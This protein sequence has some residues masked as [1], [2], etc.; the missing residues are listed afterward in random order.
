[1][2][3]FISSRCFL[4]NPWYSRRVNSDTNSM[5]AGCCALSVAEARLRVQEEQSPAIAA[6]TPWPAPS[7]SASAHVTTQTSVVGDLCTDGGGLR[8][9][10]TPE[11]LRTFVQRASRIDPLELAMQLSQQLVS[12]SWQT[13]VRALAGIQ[14]A[15]E[16][17]SSSGG[18]HAL[19]MAVA[20][21]ASMPET[22]DSVLTHPNPAVRQAALSCA[23]ALGFLTPGAGGEETGSLV[24]MPPRKDA[25]ADLLGG[26]SDE[27][28][29]GR[30]VWASGGT[31]A[32]APADDQL[33][34]LLGGEV[35]VVPP[36]LAPA[37]QPGAEIDLLG[38]L[39]TVCGPSPA[40]AVQPA[41]VE[42]VL[43]GLAL[44]THSIAPAGTNGAAYAVASKSDPLAGLAMDMVVP[45][46]QRPS[47]TPPSQPT[48]PAQGSAAG[49]AGMVTGMPQPGGVAGGWAGAARDYGE[50]SS[51][52]HA[53]WSGARP[54]AHDPLLNM[55]WVGGPGSAYAPSS[56]QPP[57]GHCPPAMLA[58]QPF[59]KEAH[60]V[61][62]PTNVGTLGAADSGEGVQGTGSAA[63]PG[64]CPTGT[65]SLG[66][67]PSKPKDAFDFVNAAMPPKQ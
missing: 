27:P 23:G 55:G 26:M 45:T 15:A 38:E 10:P 8:P 17:V 42:D 63:V 18:D 24:G 22:F 5:L 52:A 29:T 14:A 25:V 33:T 66:M 40:Q 36:A 32:T 58:G 46:P 2:A 6:A 61:G 37:A 53:G 64:T 3:R 44:A 20:S 9:Q 47:V 13:R 31:E 57:V 11:Q 49:I 48:R 39:D 51:A 7:S 4:I 16:A 34:D 30:T 19:A 65:R 43:A 62:L 67:V 41:P 59:G 35:L 54:Q 56:A 12:T 21:L 50:A 28:A 60:I 1:M